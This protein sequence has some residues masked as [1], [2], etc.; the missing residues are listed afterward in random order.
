M[1]RPSKIY[2]QSRIS[3]WNGSIL[4]RK[5]SS[6][7]QTARNSKN[8]SASNASKS[9]KRRKSRRRA[10]DP[11]QIDDFCEYAIVCMMI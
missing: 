8:F 5:R 7:R 3:S 2:R 9:R 11:P 10:S 6:A 1:N 4:T